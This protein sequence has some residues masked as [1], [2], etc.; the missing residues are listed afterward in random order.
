MPTSAQVVVLS[1]RR[2]LHVM[3]RALCWGCDVEGRYELN[4]CH[5]QFQIFLVST[6]SLL[7]PTFQNRFVYFYSLH[8]Q[9]K[10]N[11]FFN[12]SGWWHNVKKKYHFLFL[13]VNNKIIITILDC[14]FLFVIS[15]SVSIFPSS[16][17]HA[18]GVSLPKE[19]TNQTKW[20]HSL[21]APLS[22]SNVNRG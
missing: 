3:E 1:R 9:I 17:Q 21:L 10:A 11:Y 5:K 19:I 2:C 14:D 20:S 4:F 12:S 7:L 15:T 8:F 13:W 6:T 18:T 22:I 16:V